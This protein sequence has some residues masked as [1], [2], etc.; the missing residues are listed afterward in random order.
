MRAEQLTPVAPAFL[1]ALSLVVASPTSPTSLTIR[2]HDQPLHVSGDPRRPAV[3]LLSGDGGW[4]HLAPHLATWLAGSGYYAIGVD[5][6]AYLEAFTSR[7]GALSVADV[8]Q[9]LLTVIDDTGHRDASGVRPLI[10][11]VSEGAGLAVIAAGA[12]S[13]QRAVSG[14]VAVGLPAEIELG[15][16]WRDSIIYLTHGV[17]N[18]PL[19]DAASVIGR[20]APVPLALLYS[21]H[22]E[23]V[24]AAERASLVAHAGRPNRLWTVPASDH[25]FSD[26]LAA[27]DQSVHDALEWI[28]GGGR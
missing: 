25:R 21:T 18:E 5:S 27:L 12:P 17:P 19:V 28:T 7:S 26:N 9:D 11:G 6:R 8:Q 14:I 16:R 15:W 1:L 24:S 13:V 10:V 4:I 20:A 23:F 2:G 22:D 3:V